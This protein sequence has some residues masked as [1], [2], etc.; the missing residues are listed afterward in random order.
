M[1]VIIKHIVE[2]DFNV[3]AY[4]FFFLNKKERVVPSI[5]DN[6]R[7]WTKYSLVAKNHQKYCRYPETS[8]A[9]GPIEVIVIKHLVQSPCPAHRKPEQGLMVRECIKQQSIKQ[10]PSSSKTY[11]SLALSPSVAFRAYLA[12]VA[13]SCAHVGHLR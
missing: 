12:G 1:R 11:S 3:I 2:F 6:H 4:F 13:N 9:K 5:L 8:I 7:T 10:K